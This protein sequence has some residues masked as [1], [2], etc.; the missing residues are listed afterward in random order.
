MIQFQIFKVPQDTLTP[1]GVGCAR[2]SCG[3]F[4]PMLGVCRSEKMIPWMFFICVHLCSWCVNFASSDFLTNQTDLKS[5]HTSPSWTQFIVKKRCF[6]DLYQYI[7][8]YI[9]MIHFCG[10]FYHPA[11]LLVDKLNSYIGC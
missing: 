11:N 9:P 6:F 7:S 4:D 1:I 3:F 5:Q 10:S 8:Y 2:H